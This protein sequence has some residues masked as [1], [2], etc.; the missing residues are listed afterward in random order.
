LIFAACYFN[1]IDI[2]IPKNISPGTMSFTS[3]CKARLLTYA[4]RPSSNQA[5]HPDTIPFNYNYFPDAKLAD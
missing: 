1:K 5:L 4:G 3:T 2:G